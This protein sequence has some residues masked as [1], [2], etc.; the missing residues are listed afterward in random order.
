MPW[1]RHKDK[2]DPVP[3]EEVHNLVEQVRHAHEK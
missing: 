2:D 1:E 3:Y